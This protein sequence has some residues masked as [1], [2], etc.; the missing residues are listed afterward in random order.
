LNAATKVF[1][2]L[3]LSAALG[4]K[5]ESTA[6]TENLRG[7]GIALKF[8]GHE[9]TGKYPAASLSVKNINDIINAV[10]NLVSRPMRPQEILSMLIAGL[11]DI[12][13]KCNPARHELLDSV[14]CTAQTCLD[15]F[16]DDID[17]EAAFD[18]YLEW[19]S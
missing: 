8:A 9:A 1:A 14:I 16:P 18:R 17:H 11:G 4:K 7:A 15:F 12:H 6:T 3:S 5:I 10:G 19:I 2:T 13:A